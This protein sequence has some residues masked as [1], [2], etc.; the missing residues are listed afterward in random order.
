MTPS[1]IELKLAG[2]KGAHRRPA[3]KPRVSD[4][5]SSPAGSR[6]GGVPFSPDG[7]RPL[8]GQCRQPLPLLLQLDL[9]STPGGLGTGLLQVFY[10]ANPDCEQ[11]RDGWS[12]FSVIHLARI[13]DAKGGGGLAQAASD[14]HPPRTI[15]GWD[16][17]DDLPSPREHEELGLELEYDFEAQTV[18]FR[19]P[20]VGLQTPPIGI[21]DL[22]AEQI[23]NPEAGDKLLGW[24]HWIQ[25]VEYPTCP[26]C[27]S[28][29]RVL[30][31]LDSED[32]VPVMWGDA[33][34]AHISQCPNHRDVLTM[35][36]ACG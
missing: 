6:F 14:D 28:R 34:I 16:P 20:A 25:G 13:V 23:A 29:M 35:A 12:P 21:D 2:W 19:C 32:N 15:V 33:G 10:C 7:Q 24:P 5:V 30:F 26:K 22:T 8:C 4:G 31:Q 18:A 11:A 1:Q 9:E 27:R 3:W 36:W 17:I